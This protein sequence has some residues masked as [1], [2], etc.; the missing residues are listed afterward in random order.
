M[1]LRMRAQR[2]IHHLLLALGLL[3]ATACG[4]RPTAAPTPTVGTGGI[5]PTPA[6]VGSTPSPGVQSL[7]YADPVLGV[8]MS[9]PDDLLLTVGT[10]DPSR[11]ILSLTDPSQRLILQV[12]WTYEEDAEDLEAVVE[13]E[14]AEYPDLPIERA[15]TEIDGIGG[16]VL[17][18]MPGREEVTHVYLPVHDRLYRIIYVE[19][20]GRMLLDNIRFVS[21][22][23]GGDPVTSPPTPTNLPPPTTTST[24]ALIPAETPSPPPATAL[25]EG[26]V[27][28][29][30]PDMNMTVSLPPGWQ[31]TRM[32]GLYQFGPTTNFQDQ[33][34]SIGFRQDLPLEIEA[35]E[36]AARSLFEDQGETNLSVERVTVAGRQALAYRG[37]QHTCMRVLV[38]MDGIVRELTLETPACAATGEPD[39]MALMLLEHLTIGAPDG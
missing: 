5:D 10:D 23:A 3:L 6:V 1:E 35:L 19:P 38:P 33:W 16:V 4:G 11:Y 28:V 21:P 26:W 25:P 34:L 31:V 7:S 30:V 8:E 29:D 18:P 9:Y 13:Q 12:V 20:E 39:P 32:P 36:E 37:F 2:L 14:L 27:L 22:T 15:S 17:S 24:P